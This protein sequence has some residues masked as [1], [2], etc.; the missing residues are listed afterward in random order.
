MQNALKIGWIGTG[1]M[2]KSMCKHLLN[3]H[4]DMTVY[5]RTASK[6]EELVN[7]GAKVS[8]IKSIGETCDIVF[9]MVGTPKD[10]KESVDILLPSMKEGSYL[11][12]HTTSSPDLAE[13]IHAEATK[14]KIYAWDA[15]VSGGDIGAREARLVVMVGG[16]EEKFDTVKDIMLKYS[17]KINLMGGP[18]LG[19]H[20][21][22]ANQIIIAG[23][24][25]G[26]CEGMLYAHKAGLD[27][28]KTIELLGGGAASSFSLNVYGPRIIKRDFEPG[29]FVEHFL[30][31]MAIAIEESKK[32]GLK[33]K[34][35]ELAN[36]L[37]KYMTD[38]GLGKKGIQGL[39]LALEKLNNIQL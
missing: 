31:D 20:T 6:T 4:Y 26:V 21:K 2:G 38:E 35:L 28:T 16:Q 34:G 23:G 39:Y 29:F 17:G 24:I 9:L 36:E 30:K 19:Q 8:D 37:Y 11:V 33:L 32:M 13:W 3:S 12:D 5:N 25:I 1:V 10:V 27:L 18:G 15:P 14:R 22:M 7:L